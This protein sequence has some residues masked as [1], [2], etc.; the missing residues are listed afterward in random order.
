[1]EDDE[2]ENLPTERMSVHLIAGGMAGMM[3]HCVMYP[4]DCVKVSKN[5]FQNALK[6][7]FLQIITSTTS[8]HIKEHLL[9]IKLRF[10]VTFV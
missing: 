5:T 6:Y 9:Y 7:E 2:Y 8:V 10:F 4:V 3:E 1:M